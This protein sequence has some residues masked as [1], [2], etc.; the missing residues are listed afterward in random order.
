VSFQVTIWYAV[1]A[2]ERYRPM[3]KKDS[4]KKK[5]TEMPEFTFK[6]FTPEENRVYVEAVKKFRD[7]ITTGKTLRQAYESYAIA[8]KE[9]ES[10][11]R[12]DF[13]KIMI[14]E[15]HFSLHESLEDLA[16]TLD[17]SLDLIK[18]T[19]A[20]MLQEVGVT[21]ASQLDGIVPVTND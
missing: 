4:A 2:Y 19:H 8:D 5:K 11:V 18:D 3:K 14:A 9:L 16:K 6:E 17:V 15:R 13:L 20:R 7:V 1:I 12:A 10:L 21:A